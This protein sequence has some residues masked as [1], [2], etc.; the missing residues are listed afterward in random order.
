VPRAEDDDMNMEQLAE[1]EEWPIE[2]PIY[3]SAAG[4][5]RWELF[6]GGGGPGGTIEG[7]DG[8]EWTVAYEA[9][10]NY[11]GSDGTGPHAAG[12]FASPTMSLPMYLGIIC[13]EFDGQ[14]DLQCFESIVDDIENGVYTIWSWCR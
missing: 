6:V 4:E 13:E 7:P 1:I 12:R 2:W 9:F 8:K 5:P 11:P 10:A 3:Q 14:D